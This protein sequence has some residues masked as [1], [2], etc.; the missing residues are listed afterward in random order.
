MYVDAQ[1]E[2]PDP[3]FLKNLKQI[4]SNSEI[5]SIIGILNDEKSSL[6]DR[7][8]EVVESFFGRLQ[9][10]M[11]TRRNKKT[12][13]E[14]VLFFC[15]SYDICPTFLLGKN[16]RLLAK[17]RAEKGVDKTVNII[18]MDSFF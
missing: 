11:Q 3:L 6:T 16:K 7:E 1:R 9:N 18:G 8:N 17:L 13:A 10:K 12:L 2:L 4:S 5:K 14:A 15:K